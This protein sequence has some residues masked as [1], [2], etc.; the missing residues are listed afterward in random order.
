MS[1]KYKVMEQEEM[2]LVL[3]TFLIDSWS[4]SKVNTF[5]RHQAAF[6]MQYVF[7]LYS[8]MGP[9]TIAGR[10][11]HHALQFF[12][13]RLK[14][15]ELLGLPAME[16]AAFEHIGETPGNRWKLGKTTP[17]MEE[18]AQEALD[19]VNKLL[20]N[21]MIEK[22]VY[23]DN[24]AEVLDVEVYFDEFLTINGVDIPLPCH[25]QIDL[26]IRTKDGKNVIVDHKSK[27]SYTDEQE[28]AMIIGQQA[29][30]YVLGYEAKT[31][32]RIDEVWFV[33]NK[34][35]QN[36]DKSAQVKS[37]VTVMDQNARTLYENLLYEPL[38]AMIGAVKDPDYVYLINTQ[39]K[40][41]DM[42]EIYDFWTRVRICEVEDFN[43]DQS[44]KEL[45]AKRIK[46]IRD[47]GAEMVSPEIIKRF[48]ANASKF[49]QYDLS[50]TNMTPQE[51][52]EHVLRTFGIQSKIAHTFEGYSSNTFLLEIGAGVKVASLYKYRLDIAN[53]LDVENVRMSTELVVYEKKS[54]LSVDISKE[55]DKDLIFNPDDLVGH[56]LPLGKDNYGRVIT[57]DL[58]NHSTPHMLVCGATGSG[59]SV[60]INS[61]IAYAK[62]ANVPDIIILDPKYEFRH[63]RGPG[64]DVINEVTAIEQA[65]AHLVT[66]MNN[67]VESGRNK[68]ALII[69]DEYADA[70]SRSRSG[71]ELNNYKEVY[72]GTYA[73]GN[74]KYV[75]ECTSVDA[76]L[77]ENLAMLLQKGRSSGYRIIACAQR[78]SVKII[79][80]DSKAN[81]PVQVC[82]Y[83]PKEA[84]SRVVLDEAGAEGLAGRGDG[85]IK[86]PEYRDTIRF[87]AYY[88]PQ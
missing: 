59:K 15:G 86:S 54:Y 13:A 61:T 18:A 30:T 88:K 76:S 71:K 31:G 78:A 74:N 45:V 6:E 47:A 53:G 3:S 51:K 64:I 17:T 75:R 21:F 67:R 28:A 46:K 7:G 70:I 41:V 85:L 56:K 80:G 22:D 48:R 20:R 33:E 82:F 14:E 32:I 29:I 16:Q 34:P 77:G 44:K 49:I 69:F 87:Q 57:W 43:V 39:D 23:L 25:G 26:V 2:D 9:F 73:N 40:L 42:A 35:S 68:K 11:Y 10:A 52:I 8:R 65:M 84:D 37:I 19:S 55:R 4:Y 66:E 27:K 24:L 60:F 5:A 83:V 38:R 1:H 79:P 58:D 63:L 62:Q 50:V 72:A 36:K 81:F 12:F